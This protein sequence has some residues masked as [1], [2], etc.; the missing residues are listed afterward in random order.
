MCNCPDTS[1]RW[2]K[3]FELPLVVYG[4]WVWSWSL[5]TTALHLLTIYISTGRCQQRCF[6]KIYTE[7][8]MKISCRRYNSR[9]LLKWVIGLPGGWLGELPGGWLGG[10]PTK[11]LGGLPSEWLGGLPSEWLD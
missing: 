6:M 2:V 7:F 3:H 10:L 5:L 9:S 11:W 8:Y 4:E 1:H